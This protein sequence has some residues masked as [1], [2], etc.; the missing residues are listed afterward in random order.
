MDTQ[1]EQHR[2]QQQ[3][4]QQQWLPWSARA[5]APCFARCRTRPQHRRAKT[6]EMY[7]PLRA[8]RAGC[9][10]LMSAGDPLAEGRSPHRGTRTSTALTP[11]HSRTACLA[12]AA[13][14]TCQPSQLQTG[15]SFP[16]NSPVLRPHAWT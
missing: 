8:E 6:P 13:A 11:T 10:W 12:A 1:Q 14:A 4:Q 9:S 2:P 15:F 3:Q 7:A 16:G 5:R